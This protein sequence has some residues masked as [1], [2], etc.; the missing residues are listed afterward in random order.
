M[1][2]GKRPQTYA[3]DRA[4]IGAEQNYGVDGGENIKELG[5]SVSLENEVFINNVVLAK[6]AAFLL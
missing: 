2:A 1:S 5:D 3:L 6:A 4:D